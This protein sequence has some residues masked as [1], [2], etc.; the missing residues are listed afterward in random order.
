MTLHATQVQSMAIEQFQSTG[1]A[2]HRWNN[3]NK[4]NLQVIKLDGESADFRTA[5]T[6]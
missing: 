1:L 5:E 6:E 4:V 3:R 2:R